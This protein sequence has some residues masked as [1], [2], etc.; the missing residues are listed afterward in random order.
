[1]LEYDFY[2]DTCPDVETIVRSIM[3]RIYSDHKDVPAAIRLFFH[4][5]FIKGCDASVFLDDSNG[6][7]SHRR[8]SIPNKT[9]KGFDKI[10]MIT[11]ELEKVF[12]RVVSC[13]DT[14]ALATRD[15]I[16]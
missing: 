14:I 7:K 11:E 4:D 8:E 10:D 5:C 15:G 12:P 1:S 6:I 16:V 2:K 13:A 3:A 9:L